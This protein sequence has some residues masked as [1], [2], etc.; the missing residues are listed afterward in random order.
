MDR[1]IPHL[2]LLETVISPLAPLSF[3][4]SK[5]PFSNFIHTWGK[6]ECWEPPLQMLTNPELRVCF[7][8]FEERIKGTKP[9][10]NLWLLEELLKVPQREI[11]ELKEM[12]QAREVQWRD[13]VSEHTKQSVLV[14]WW[15]KLIFSGTNQREH[16]NHSLGLLYISFKAVFL[17]KYCF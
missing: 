4:R 15:N 1:T 14:H 17:E 16:A 9:H 8:Q 7:S 6:I 11:Q 5:R 10:I 3:K 13:Q 12:L 2:P